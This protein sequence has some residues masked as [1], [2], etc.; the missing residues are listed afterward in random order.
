IAPGAHLG[1]RPA[2]PS[3]RRQRPTGHARITDASGAA[4]SLAPH[5]PAR[6]PGLRSPSP[7]EREEE[8][9]DLPRGVATAACSWMRL[10]LHATSNHCSVGDS[11]DAAPFWPNSTLGAQYKGGF[12]ASII[13][14]LAER[15]AS[16]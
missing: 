8:E 7:R 5:Q 16:L 3:P 11:A 2:M 13:R 10:L 6:R 9:L 1:R 4:S 15:R 12:P 14:N